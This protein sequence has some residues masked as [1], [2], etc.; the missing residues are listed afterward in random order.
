M[1]EVRAKRCGLYGPEGSEHGITP[2][3]R[4]RDDLA[5]C[6]SLCSPLGDYSGLIAPSRDP[7]PS[8]LCDAFK[9]RVAAHAYMPACWYSHV[10]FFRD[11]LA[12]KEER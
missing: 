2:A 6:G 7:F 1:P 3:Q 11:A 5:K 8:P 12:A 4:L 10:W 9:E